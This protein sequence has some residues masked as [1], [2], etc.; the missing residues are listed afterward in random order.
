M[1]CYQAV[2]D[3]SHCRLQADDYLECLHHRKEVRTLAPLV[4]R[5]RQF[6]LV[7]DDS[8]LLTGGQVARA[9]AVQE[10]LAKQVAHAQKEGKKMSD[11]RAGGAVATLGLIDG[12]SD[13]HGK[14]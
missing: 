1:Q 5:A 11:L 12:D 6:R 14:K 8:S 7:A 3:P 2:D 13:G 4:R 10:E 9:Q